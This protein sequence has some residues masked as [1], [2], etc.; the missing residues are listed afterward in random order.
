ML[1]KAADAHL[2]LERV[3]PEVVVQRV[4]QLLWVEVE[5][6]G[7]LVDRGSDLGRGRDFRRRDFAAEDVAFRQP[8]IDRFVE[9][10]EQEMALLGRCV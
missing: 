4:G 1:E 7:A 5:R 10:L 6:A 3:F 8:V 2:G 9:Q